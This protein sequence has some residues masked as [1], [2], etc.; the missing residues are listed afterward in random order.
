MTLTLD[1]P[2]SPGWI[3]AFYNMG[4]YQSLVGADP[5]QFVFQGNRTTVSVRDDQAQYVI[6]YF[7][8]WLPTASTVLKGRL[9]AAEVHRQRDL[10]NKLHQQRE[11]EERNLRVNRTLRV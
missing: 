4:S 3:Q 11:A 10:M 2:V 7:K 5:G 9:E 8:G 1:R 6:D